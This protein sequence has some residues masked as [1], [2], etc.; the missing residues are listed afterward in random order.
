MG[1]WLNR[2]HLRGKLAIILIAGFFL[3]MTLLTAFTVH[4]LQI[5]SQQTRMQEMQ[6]TMEHICDHL[7]AHFT[8]AITL[9]LN[10][11]TDTTLNSMLDADYSSPYNYLITY[12][13]IIQNKLEVSPV[14]SAASG[15]IVYTDNPTVLPGKTVSVVP[16]VSYELDNLSGSLIPWSGFSQDLFIRV[17]AS[18]GSRISSDSDVSLVRNMNLMPSAQKHRRILRVSM[19]L[20]VLVSEL[21]PADPFDSFLLLDED[22]QVLVSSS[23]AVST[24]QVYDFG[25]IG[26]DRRWMETGLKS[27][28][29][30]RLIGIFPASALTREFSRILFP[31]IILS[32]AL[33]FLGLVFAGLTARNI[34][35]R[36]QIIGRHT[37]GIAEGRFGTLDENRMGNDEVGI[38]ARDI[39]LMSRQLEAYIQKEYLNEL[40][41][42]Q[43]QREKA[44]AEL[45]A[46]Q[47]QVNP[48]FMFN[49]LEAIRIKA[50]A[51]GETE[52]ARM[53][54]YMSRMFRRL[55]DWHDDLIPLREELAFI[56]EFLAIQKY[57]YDHAFSLDVQTEEELQDN[58]IPKM[59]I[60]PLVE[61]ACVHGLWTE[62]DSRN[63]G[64]YITR[65]E[66]RMRIMVVDHG[67]GMTEE[68]LAEVRQL[69]REGNNSMHSVGLN[70]VLV[71]CRLYYGDAAHMDVE[72]GQSDGT[73]FTLIVPLRWRKE[74]FHVSGS[75]RG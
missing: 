9:S 57:R 60:Q 4:R 46:L 65:E 31:Y 40:Q 20:P 42:A 47:S 51:L 23:P 49:A 18:N 72:P 74:D 66:D 3:P 33:I 53:I 14:Y 39:D 19:N 55:L 50:K 62:D 52:T 2:I 61:N 44:T 64:L 21:L 17:L 13:E 25:Q 38:L 22:G 41:H 43:L 48:H 59:L 75:D 36:L 45:H 15:I 54:T 24:L 1:R 68:R 30:L 16:A 26:K 10:V 34:T 73:V 32:L 8:Q 63:A 67:E 11:V 71:R 35:R 27:C 70:N 69:L 28:P 5:S 29:S 7:D 37:Q 12:Q 58:Y 6:R 56:Q